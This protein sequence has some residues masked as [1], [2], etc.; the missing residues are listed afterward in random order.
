MSDETVSADTF[1]AGLKATHLA[2]RDFGHGW[3]PHTVHAIDGGYL[4]VFRCRSCRTERHQTLNT[5]GHVMQNRY[6]YADGY[7]AAHVEPGFSRDVF[8]LEAVLRFLDLDNR[9]AV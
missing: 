8:R 6:V 1:A 9:K 3:R 2:C 7:L 4:R 5:R